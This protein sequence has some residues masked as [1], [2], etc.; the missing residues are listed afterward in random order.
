MAGV[1]ADK[2]EVDGRDSVALEHEHERRR[3]RGLNSGEVT[4][5]RESCPLVYTADAKTAKKHG[6]V[7][8]QVL[9]FIRH[10]TC[11]HSLKRNSV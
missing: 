5:N 10:L 1:S 4:Q 6:L 9:V 8:F 11:S 2:E 3:R 7:L